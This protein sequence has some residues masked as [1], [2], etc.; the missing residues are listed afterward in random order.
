MQTMTASGE[1]T[2]LT[3]ERV[4]AETE[5]ALKSKSPQVYFEVLRQCGALAVLFP[6]IDNLFGV[7]APAKWYPEIDTGIHT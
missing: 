2:H 6:E 5:K 4:W 3:A 7:P 1:L